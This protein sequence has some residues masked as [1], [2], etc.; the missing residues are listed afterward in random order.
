MATAEPIAKVT[1]DIKG[2]NAEEFVSGLITVSP[3]SIRETNDT[4]FGDMI[5]PTPEEI[6]I[7][8]E[9]MM[10]YRLTRKMSILQKT[11]SM[12]CEN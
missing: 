2:F 10:V 5:A 4:C 6:D 8:L 11:K 12:G 9:L 1:T 7:M 3:T